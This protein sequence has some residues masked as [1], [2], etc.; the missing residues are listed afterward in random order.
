MDEYDRLVGSLTPDVYERLKR[1]VET[2]RWPD[3]REVTAV[4]REHCLTAIIAW[5]ERNL[6]PQERVGFIDRGR[7]GGG[8]QLGAVSDQPLRWQEEKKADGSAR[9]DE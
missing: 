5:G 7:K 8:T 9:G 6:P 3:G 4:Q 2:G 1:A